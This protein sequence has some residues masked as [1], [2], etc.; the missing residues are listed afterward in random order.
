MKREDEADLKPYTLRS[1]DQH[2]GKPT[3]W[4]TSPEVA[5]DQGFDFWPL[6]HVHQIRQDGVTATYCTDGQGASWI[7]FCEE[8]EA[9]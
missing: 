3:K 5:R 8:D 4:F 7:E 9:L 1:R 2:A 6:G